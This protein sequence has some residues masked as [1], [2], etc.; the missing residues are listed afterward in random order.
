MKNINQNA[1]KMISN[2]RLYNYK[3]NLINKTNK[4]NNK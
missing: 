2:I 3:K 4:G 1:L